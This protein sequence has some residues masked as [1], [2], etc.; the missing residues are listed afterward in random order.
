MSVHAGGTHVAI[1]FVNEPRRRINLFTRSVDSS[2][3]SGIRGVSSS[4]KHGDTVTVYV[5]L[6]LGADES[7][8]RDF[9][10]DMA[11]SIT[12]AGKNA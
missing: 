12:T 11:R 10:L 4:Y 8:C 1:K 6:T 5:E 9:L 2:N 7:R 3:A